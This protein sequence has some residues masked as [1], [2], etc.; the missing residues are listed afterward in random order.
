[1]LKILLNIIGIILIIY[2][3]YIIKKDN[4]KEY[5][6]I[7]ELDSIEGRVKEYYNLTEEIIENFDGII[8]SKLE[9]L[10]RDNKEINK[11]ECL[12]ENDNTTNNIINNMNGND[13][14]NFSHKKIIELNSIGLTKEEIAK[15]LNKGIREID[16]VLKMYYVKK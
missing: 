5:D 10:N 6:V 2:S 3:L 12:S 8:D 7:N 11:D 9:M 14:M 16:M 1:M 15:K 13:S 4:R